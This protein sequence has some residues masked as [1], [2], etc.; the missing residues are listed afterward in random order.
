VKRI[1]I[2]LALATPTACKDPFYAEQAQRCANW[3]AR[4]TSD[5][6]RLQIEMKCEEMTSAHQNAQTVA[7]AAITAGILASTK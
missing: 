1:L 6:E 7:N 3:T 5:A 4:A 2:F